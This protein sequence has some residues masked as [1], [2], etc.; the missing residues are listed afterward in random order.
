MPVILDALLWRL[1]D[2]KGW[3]RCLSLGIGST[4]DFKRTVDL[5]LA[6]F[7]GVVMGSVFLLPLGIEHEILC[8][9]R[10]NLEGA[11]LH[12]KLA[13]LYTIMLMSSYRRTA[14]C[15]IYAYFSVSAK[16]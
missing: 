2:L 16:K 5:S 3:H 12:H 13:T 15:I 9:A 8:T 14:E 10:A 4:G 11:F 7:F 1:G 6:R